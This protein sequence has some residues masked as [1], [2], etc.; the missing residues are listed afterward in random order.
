MTILKVERYLEELH[1]DVRATAI[2]IH[3]KHD[4]YVT[5]EEL[6]N[7]TRK[8]LMNLPSISDISLRIRNLLPWTIV[9]SVERDSEA[10]FALIARPMR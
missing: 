8:L 4:E 9:Q 2:S 6:N 7:I 1:H 10:D 5:F 3:V